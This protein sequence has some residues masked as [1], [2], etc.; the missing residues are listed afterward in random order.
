VV[1]ED[2]VSCSLSIKRSKIKIDVD[3]KDCEVEPAV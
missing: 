2:G 1:E 3:D